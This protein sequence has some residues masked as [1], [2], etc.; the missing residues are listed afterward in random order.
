M[1]TARIVAVLVTLL[2]VPT[3]ASRARAQG[4]NLN[5]SGPDALVLTVPTAGSDF[6]L[7]WTGEYHDLEVPGGA[8]FEVCLQGCDESTDPVCEVAGYAGGQE[9][10]GRSF[11]PP[12]PVVGGSVPVCVVT[13]FQEP[14]ATGTA[15]VQTGAIAVS[16]AISGDVYL[17][18]NPSAVCPECS[19]ATPGATGTC[20]SG[21]NQGQACTTG[22]VI[23][24]QGA[25]G[26]PSYAVSR[27]CRPAGAPISVAFAL[28]VGT[29]TSSVG[30]LC[31]GQTQAHDCGAGTCSAACSGP[32]NGGVA[33]TCCSNVPSRRCFADPVARTGAAVPPQPAWP[34]PTWPKTASAAVTSAF[35]APGAP[36]GLVGGQVNDDVGLPGPAA[37]ILPV[38][39]EWLLDPTS[40]TTTTTTTLPAAE[41]TTGADCADA[42][43]CTDD[44]CS[45]GRCLH[46]PSA[47]TA[48]VACRLNAFSAG[49]VCG[50]AV[51]AKLDAVLAKLVRKANT[52]V[53]GIIG[54]KTGKV[55]KLRKRARG[56]L[57]TA[58]RRVTKAEKK[59]AVDGPCAAALRAAITRLQ[60]AVAG[61]GG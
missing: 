23:T 13:T 43:A 3:A 10:A 56:A 50:T 39:A 17:S 36:P 26:D 44:T 4:C 7:G 11:A 45:A 19:G 27:D 8:R 29:G 54:A 37:F 12:I 28:Q 20:T 5:A 32:G 60:E 33:Q 31:P 61:I 2:L 38:A 46:V 53:G 18:L 9:A 49:D 22:E 57:A 21:A 51:D 52:A 16:A 59:D 48:G 40:P 55:A 6:D 35:C 30:G 25:V 1:S 47:G 15:D 34:D 14:F 58:L 41:C 42:D 24:V